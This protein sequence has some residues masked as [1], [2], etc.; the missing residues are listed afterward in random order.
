MSLPVKRPELTD[1]LQAFKRR[2]LQPGL[3]SLFINILMLTGPL[4]ML[5]V[6]DRVVTSQSVP[7][8]IAL[9]VLI[10]FLYASLGVLLWVRSGLLN[11]AA[12]SFERDLDAATVDASI[13]LRLRD[14]ENFDESTVSHLR[15]LRNFL[16]GPV[17]ASILDAPFTPIFFVILF[18]LHPAFGYWGLIGAAILI[19]LSILNQR[20]TAASLRSTQEKEDEAQ[21]RARELFRNAEAA[22]ALGM[23]TRLRG[24]WA[25]SG[26]I[27]D[28]ASR[29]AASM[30]S[31]F[32]SVTRAF[33]LFLQSAILGLGAYLAI[34]GSVSFGAMIAASIL[35]GRAIAPIEQLVASWK[36]VASAYSS[37]NRL[38]RTI[39]AAGEHTR[40]PMALPPITGRVS[41]E[42]I[43]IVAAG[44]RT[45]ILKALNF[46]I[47]AGDAVGIL[48]PSA[49][50]K[51]TLIK[52]LAGIL[53]PTTGSIRIDGAELREF[54]PSVLGKQMGYLP[55]QIELLS[56]TVRQNIARFD[57][58]AMPEDV[59]KAAKSAGCHDLILRL[60][61]GYDTEIGPS[62]SYLSA[63][64]RQRIGLA[65]ALFGDP[66]LVLL[67]E[68]NSNLDLDGEKA[69]Q[70]AIVAMRENE[71]TVMIVAHRP[72]SIMACNKLLVLDQGELKAFGPRDE[73]LSSLAGQARGGK[74]RAIRPAETSN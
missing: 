47:D 70:N 11:E 23:R 73:I 46:K 40:T 62:G 12:S 22:E 54:D 27:S 28:Q 64:Q 59:I 63:G 30:L 71:T 14:P 39:S 35:L 72:Q 49:A 69:L 32:D 74:L 52:A 60:S 36:S 4:Y 58:D 65:R 38:E 66:K 55:Q 67:D 9:T 42:G 61:A 20:V 45:P 2:L 48:G 43:Y 16:A 18:M 17:V 56:G 5:Q 34:Q 41:A 25:A 53:P 15:K 1:A 21:S 68:P 6:Y 10:L 29:H 37:W 26:A 44:S 13:A 8:L 51:T 7:T 57:E 19:A 3:F 33:R 50:G 31:G 24:Q